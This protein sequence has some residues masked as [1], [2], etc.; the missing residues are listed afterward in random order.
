MQLGPPRCGRG[1]CSFPLLAVFF[2]CAFLVAARPAEAHKI[3]VWDPS[4]AKLIVEDG[5]QLLADYGSFQLYEVDHVRPEVLQSDHAEVRDDSNGILLNAALI[6]TS[7]TAGKSLRQP[8]GAFSGKRLHLV[9]FIGPVQKA[10]HEALKKTG[11]QIIDYLPENTYLVY[12]DAPSLA[13]LQR[14]T[15][16]TAYV[17][18]DGEYQDSY[19]I[20][21]KARLVD[22]NGNSQQ[23][24][25][26]EFAIQLVADPAANAATLAL[27]DRLKLEP[28][29]RQYNL[30]QYVN[31]LVRLRIQ[32][33]NLIAA[34]PDVVS[35]QPHHAPR[36]QD[37]RQDQIVAGN[38]T[39]DAPTAPGYLA[40]LA[41]KGFT[42]AQFTASGFAVDISDSGIDNGTITPGHFALYEL[43]DTGNASRV[44]YNRLAGTPNNPGSTLEGCDGHG[45]LNAHIV[46]GYDNQPPASPTRMPP[47]IITTSVSVH[48][49]GL[50]LR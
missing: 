40:W 29:H 39:G 34:Q 42:Q 18:W 32:D 43:G 33:L 14:F 5:G 2:L 6:D 45:N 11:A 28:I 1:P 23:L 21:P 27:I 47:A 46:C 41:S 19:R 10:W 12:G 36:K 50:G 17:Q 4:I 25:T 37:E 44:I 7:T 30:L 31:V 8:V 3:K 22:A 49:S 20:H 9:Q 24:T 16:T 38:L 13:R 26:D 35:I 48:S 15:G